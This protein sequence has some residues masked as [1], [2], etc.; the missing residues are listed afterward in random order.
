M[1]QAKQELVLAMN[2]VN[3]FCEKSQTTREAM[4][5][6]VAVQDGE[7]ESCDPHMILDLLV[8]MLRLESSASQCIPPAKERAAQCYQRLIGFDGT[9]AHRRLYQEWLGTIESYEQERANELAEYEAIRAGLACE[10]QAH[11]A[12]EKTLS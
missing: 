3:D 12:G 2:H 7:G 6:A 5:E 4:Q 9:D 10:I 8:T 1:E 11:I